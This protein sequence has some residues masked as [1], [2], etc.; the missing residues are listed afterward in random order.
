MQPQPPADLP[1]RDLLDPVQPPDL[2]PLLHADHP[3]SSPIDN[4]RSRV[5]TRPDDTSP[6][7]GGSLSDRRRWVTIQAAPTATHG[8][9]RWPPAG[10]N[11]GRLRGGSHGHR[12]MTDGS[13]FVVVI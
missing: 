9:N 6:A 5:R 3:S 11:D 2:R 1:N 13:I 7:P 10:R 12:H 8:E 4:D